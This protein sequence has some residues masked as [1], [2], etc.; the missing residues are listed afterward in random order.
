M[1][2][3]SLRSFPTVRNITVSGRIASG[4]TTLAR[5]LADELGWTFLEG[6]ELFEKF[7]DARKG[8]DENRPDQVDLEYEEMVK[9]MLQEKEH[10]VIQSHLAGFD[11]QGIS[12][13]FKVGVLCEDKEGSDKLDIRIDRLLNRK[14]VSV[15]EAKKEVKNREAGL[16]A[17]WRRLY[18]NNDPEWI[19]W[20]KKY[21][22]TIVNTYMLN[23]EESL[24]FVLEQLE[25]LDNSRS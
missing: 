12:G 22:D 10:Q 6:G 8:S 14:G 15:E 13:V 2:K 20:D 1:E 21:F 7:F 11:A 16:L 17:K 25:K 19:Y 24:H 18:A 4:A 3:K 9:G 23:K 5:Q